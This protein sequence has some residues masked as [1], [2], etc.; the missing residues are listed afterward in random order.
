MSTDIVEANISD[1]NVVF[2]D[3]ENQISGYFDKITEMQAGDIIVK[4]NC[5][6]CNHPLRNQAELK[7]EQSK[8]SNGKGNCSAIARFLNE[9]TEHNDGITFSSININHHMLNHYEQQQR[10]IWLRE[11]GKHLASVMNY[12][13]NRDSMFETLLQSMYMKMMEVASDPTLDSVKQ[14][15]TMTKLTKSIGEICMAQA[16]LRGEIEP[17]EAFKEKFHQ[18]IVSFITTE[19]D[20]NRQRLLMNHLE[21]LKENT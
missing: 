12:K 7:W 2:Q 14:A 9:S 17:V 18:I 4:G 1:N 8:S 16:R 11:Y 20:P 6:L 5:K 15:E 3:V 13:I 21:K 10:R 19:K